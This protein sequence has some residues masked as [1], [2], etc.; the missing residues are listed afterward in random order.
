MTVMSLLSARRAWV[1]P[2]LL[3]SL[4]LAVFESAVVIGLG[5]TYLFTVM[6]FGLGVLLALPHDRWVRWTVLVLMTVALQ[7]RALAAYAATG[8][9][10]GWAVWT[11]LWT[12]F[13]IQWSREA[14][15]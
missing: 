13:V 12:T 8:T 10:V 14:P 3:M 1:I 7:S 2:Y 5:W 6:A 4:C 15:R 11:T 9:P